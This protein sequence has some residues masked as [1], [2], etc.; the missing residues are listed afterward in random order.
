MAA[1]A[2]VRRNVPID[3]ITSLVT[4]V[5]EENFTE[6]LRFLYE[7]HGGPTE[8]ISGLAQ[9]LIAIARH[10]VKVDAAILETL[11]AMA[12]RIRVKTRGLSQKNRQRLAAF[13]DPANVALHLRLPGHL[14]RLA[15]SQSGRKAA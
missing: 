10:Q 1:S 5:S 2:L 12:G 15:K 13:D 6:I 7:R 8:A 9:G 11:S 4:L 14:A 3:R